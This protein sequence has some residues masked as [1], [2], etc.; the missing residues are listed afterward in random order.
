MAGGVSL[1]ASFFSPAMRV[2][3]H[4]LHAAMAASWPVQSVDTFLVLTYRLCPYVLVER[5]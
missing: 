4:S 1:I 3:M 5:V 2:H